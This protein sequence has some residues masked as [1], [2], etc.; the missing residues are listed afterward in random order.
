MSMKYSVGDKVRI[1]DFSRLEQISDGPAWH[2]S[3]GLYVTEKMADYQNQVATITEILSALDGTY[4]ID[5]DNGRY[6]WD[7]DCFEDVIPEGTVFKIGDVLTIVP[8]PLDEDRRTPDGLTIA[9]AM[10]EYYGKTFTVTNTGAEN[11]V[12]LNEDGV[13]HL[14]WWWDRWCLRFAD[15]FREVN[16]DGLEELL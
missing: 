9:V 5:I 4:E 2:T 1:V 15:E 13:A 6:A 10:E 14:G 11:R 16:F 7:D 3:K 12:I 8:P